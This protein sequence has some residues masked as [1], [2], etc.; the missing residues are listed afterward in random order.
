MTKA[1]F[2]FL[3]MIGLLLWLALSS[4]AMEMD[5]SSVEISNSLDINSTESIFDDKAMDSSGEAEAPN[6]SYSTNEITAWKTITDLQ[7]V[8]IN[9]RDYGNGSISEVNMWLARP[10]Q[11]N[12]KNSNIRDYYLTVNLKIDGNSYKTSYQDIQAETREVY[13][14]I[15]DRIKES[16]KRTYSLYAKDYYTSDSTGYESLTDSDVLFQSNEPISMTTSK[17]RYT[18]YQYSNRAPRSEWVEQVEPILENLYLENPEMYIPLTYPSESS[19]FVL[20][21]GKIQSPVIIRESWEF[22]FNDNSYAIVTACNIASDNDCSGLEYYTF[23]DDL[24]RAIYRFTV[25]FVNDKIIEVNK[26]TYYDPHLYILYEKTLDR[27]GSTKDMTI[28][29]P[30]YTTIQSGPDGEL[31]LC[32]SWLDRMGYYDEFMYWPC[33][34]VIDTDN[35]SIPELLSSYDYHFPFEIINHPLY[36]YYPVSVNQISESNLHF[37]G[38]YATFFQ[39]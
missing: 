37:S 39:P 24:Q 27:I 13:K 2:K 28:Y 19:D 29:Q 8:D 20:I 21:P 14:L 34:V 15:W 7:S 32:N 11:F 31:V 33:F 4:C 12:N 16:N 17:V 3:S 6:K 9:S 10:R 22:V 5:K 36:R 25:V 1:Y 23:D 38:Y 18:N 35:D 26:K 30:F